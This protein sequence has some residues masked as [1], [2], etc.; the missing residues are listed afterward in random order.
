[1]IDSGLGMWPKPGPSKNFQGFFP[2]WSWQ[3]RSLFAVVHKVVS[4]ELLVGFS[5]RVPVVLKLGEPGQI[6]EGS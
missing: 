2:L 5:L 1:M 6:P 4:L 3:G